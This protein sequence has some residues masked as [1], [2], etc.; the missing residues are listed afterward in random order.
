MA[1][2]NPYNVFSVH[3]VFE[4]LAMTSNYSYVT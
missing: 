1:I 3:K 2:Q 4:Q